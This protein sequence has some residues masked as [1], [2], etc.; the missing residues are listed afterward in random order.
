MSETPRSSRNST[1][2]MVDHSAFPGQAP[3]TE[4]IKNAVGDLL[5]TFPDLKVTVEDLIAE[6]DKVVSRETWRG[7]HGPTGKAA[8]GSIIHIF[9]ISEGT[10]T[11]EWSLGWDWLEKL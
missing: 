6:G 2:N 1:P 8:T 5:E 10:I 7:T 4:G 11:D 3:G 9:R